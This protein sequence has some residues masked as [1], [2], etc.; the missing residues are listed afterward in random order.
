M[1]DTR[2]Q[3]LDQAGGPQ[4]DTPGG[5]RSAAR[6]LARRWGTATADR[7]GLPD[8]LVVGT[9]RGGTTTLFRALQSHPG[10]APLFPSRQHTKSPHYFDLHYDR[11][12]SW[13]RSFFP[14]A[15][16]LGR[17]GHDRLTGE[18][19]P[20]YMFHPL[21]PG[22][23]ASDLPSVRLL[24]LLRDPV[25]RA[26]S[27]HWDRV[28][29]G[30]EHLP[31]ELAVAM[32]P[33][34]LAGEREHMEADPGYQSDAYE[35]FSYLARGHYAEQVE[36]LIAL[37]GRDRLLVARSEDLYADPQRTYDEVLEFLGLPSHRPGTFGRHHAHDGRPPV[38]DALR[39]DLAT[40][41]APH[42]ERLAEL[43]G[44]DVWW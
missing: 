20:Y 43:L 32:E 8:F 17:A 15:R 40:Y 24:V 35:H 16:A 38:P 30:V 6:A 42:N 28:Q 7:R 27:H 41:F 44:T 21:A 36:R 11:G 3:K 9:K 29:H 1:T 4:P 19:S 12:E 13:Y 14:T 10:V 37:F 39:A 22:R 5:I 26:A 33:E 25:D 34:R 23:I 31:F 18:A 2:P